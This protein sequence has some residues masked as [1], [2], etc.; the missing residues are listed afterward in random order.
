MIDHKLRH[1]KISNFGINRKGLGVSGYSQDLRK[2]FLNQSMRCFVYILVNGSKM[3][4]E[5]NPSS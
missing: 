5:M 4:Q 2:C 1:D 3:V